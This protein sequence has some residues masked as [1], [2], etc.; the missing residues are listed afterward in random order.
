MR[1]D[2]RRVKWT[3]WSFAPCLATALLMVALTTAGTTTVRPAS[4]VQPVVTPKP[5]DQLHTSPANCLIKYVDNPHFSDSVKGAV[6]VNARAQCDRPV[7]ENDL[8]VTL[9]GDNMREITE[10][11]EKSTG[12]AFVENK[13]TY[14]H[15]KNNTE[16]HTFQGAAMGTSWEDGKP[17]VQFLF[18][19]KVQLNCGY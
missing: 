9:F 16:T 11:V 7:A 17:Y 19:N 15:C 8:S 5:A 6:K 3:C 18:G 14:V 1:S 4:Y 10:T 12:K 2:Q 13:G